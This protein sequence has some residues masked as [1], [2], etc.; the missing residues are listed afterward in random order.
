[1]ILQEGCNPTVSQAQRL[2]EAAK[3]GKLD[4][5]GMELVLQ[6]EKPQ[7]N[8]ITIKANKLEKYF[9]KNYTPKQKEDMII[10]ALDL[11]HKR[12]ERIRQEREHER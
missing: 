10:R 11:Y 9:P 8:N 4:H 5:N 2:K 6:E 1:M 3:A 12:M 7:Q